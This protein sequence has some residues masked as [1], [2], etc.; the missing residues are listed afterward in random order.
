MTSG[1]LCGSETEALTAPGEIYKHYKGGVYRLVH[2]GVKHSETG[3]VG[4]L[5][6]HFWPH[7][8]GYWFRPEELFFGS[9]PDGSPRFILIKR[10]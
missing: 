4:V 7:E 3:E 1:P 10:D 9:L 2:R 5:Y 8:H 6:E